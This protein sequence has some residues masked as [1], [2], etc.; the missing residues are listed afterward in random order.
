MSVDSNSVALLP[1]SAG[2]ALGPILF[3][4]A[5][6]GILAAIIS[7]SV[8][9]F[10]GNTTND[11]AKVMAQT[12]IQ[13]SEQVQATAQRLM[14]NGCTE[15]QLNFYVPGYITSNSNAPSD[16]SCNVFDPR[17]GGLVFVPLPA[18]ACPVGTCVWVATDGNVIPGVGTGVPQPL[19]MTY[20]LT[21]AV[22]QQINI[23]LGRST[24]NTSTG[25]V[26]TNYSGTFPT[27]ATLNG[28]YTGVNAGC[29]NNGTNVWI[30]YRVLWTR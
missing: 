12:I 19:W 17:G 18:A 4:I 13:E 22:C 29:V 23:E 26:G 27:L 7:V 14:A 16:G 20:Y 1:T 10:S 24:I 30:F 11:S 3:I 6:I 28:A 25:M 9:G 2:I 8:N 15:A 5:I 21:T